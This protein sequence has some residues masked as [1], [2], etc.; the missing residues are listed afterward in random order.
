MSAPS[1][2]RH[3]EVDTADVRTTT[4]TAPP[5][6]APAQRPSR[7]GRWWLATLALVALSILLARAAPPDSAAK[8]M[9]AL[10]LSL[11]VPGACWRLFEQYLHWRFPT[12]S[13]HTVAGKW[14]ARMSAASVLAQGAL[15]ALGV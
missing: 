3:N 7:E 12:A 5:A 2:G 6:A 1:S 10:T 11:L 4:R 13:M 15:L 9:L 8:A 14:T